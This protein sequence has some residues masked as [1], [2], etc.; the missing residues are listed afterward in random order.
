MPMGIAHLER[1]LHVGVQAGETLC[2]IVGRSV[3]SNAIEAGFERRALG[4][5]VAAAAVRVCSVLGN[6]KPLFLLPARQRYWNVRGGTAKMQCRECAWRCP[7]DSVCSQPS[8]QAKLRDLALLLSRFEQLGRRRVPH[9]RVQDRQNLSSALA[10]CAHDE[11]AAEP[12]FILTVSFGE[13]KLR[14]VILRHGRA[15]L[16]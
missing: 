2:L 4:Q 14:Y 9:A 3:E 15:L 7:L 5:K 11:D 12:L 8:A 1:D 10:R 16:G 6:W 13:G